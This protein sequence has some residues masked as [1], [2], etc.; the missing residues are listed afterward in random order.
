MSVPYCH[1]CRKKPDEK[2]MYGDAM[3]GQGAYCPICHQPACRYH[4][5]RVRWRWKDT[6][7]IES[8]WICVE[9]KNGYQHRY[10]D[11]HRR[12]WID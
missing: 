3:L 4:M 9:C 12:D 1:V 6:G 2:E 5:A 10:W 8:D 11:S 7:R